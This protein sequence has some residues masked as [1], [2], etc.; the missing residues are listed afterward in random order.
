MKHFSPVQKIFKLIKIA[1]GKYSKYVNT[2][3]PLT[4]PFM[5]RKGM[6]INEEKFYI[7]HSYSVSLVSMCSFATCGGAGD[8]AREH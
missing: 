3:F 5:V 2:A 1:L 4:A 8:I 7:P 6:V